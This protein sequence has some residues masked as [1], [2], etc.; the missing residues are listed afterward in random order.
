M[1]DRVQRAARLTAASLGAFLYA[2]TS[3]ATGNVAYW[4]E[5]RSTQLFGKQVI[6]ALADKARIVV[7]RAPAKGPTSGYDYPTVVARIKSATPG[8]PVLAYAQPLRIVDKGRIETDVLKPDLPVAVAA[9][10]RNDEAG[11][12]RFVDIDNDASRG[13]VVDTLSRARSRLNV[14]G[15]ALDLLTRT[16]S[17]VPQALAKRCAAEKDYCERYAAGVDAFLAELKQRLQAGY[18]IYNGLFTSRPGLLQ[19]QL[20]LLNTADAAIV[21]YFGLNPNRREHSFS[22]DI[23]PYLKAMQQL[24][25]D[26]ALF[27]FGRGP[28]SYT[29]Y[30]DDYRWQRYLYASFLLAARS[31]DSFKYH[32]SFQVPAHKGRSGGF[33]HYADWDL[34]LGEPLESMSVVNGLYQRR[35]AN[36]LVIVAPD[37][38]PGGRLHLAQPY[39]NPEGETLQG[40]L[41]FAAGEAAILLTRA[42][43]RPPVLTSFDAKAIA[44]WGWQ[45][46][47]LEQANGGTM[48]RLAPLPDKLAGEHD[49][50]LEHSRS[51][52]TFNTLAIDARLE[53][54]AAAIYAVAE[55]DDAR[56]EHMWLVVA[57]TRGEGIP[58]T[59]AERV[60]FRIPTPNASIPWPHVERPDIAS[61]MTLDGEAIA[62]KAGL[63]FRRWSHVRFSGQVGIFSIALTQPS[64]LR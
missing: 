35:F 59:S 13:L 12:I 26:K 62:A 30:V 7:I 28:W 60:L 3:A 29:D 49:L 17:P 48:L 22:I 45:H 52:S 47:A 61:P 11:T 20:R 64:A 42:P 21:E 15:F 58:A 6:A 24:P 33:D 16:P 56:R 31:Q 54:D 38:G 50:L 63:K 9:Q 40:D 36:G 19:D 14:D 18:L 5:P 8:T 57:I 32:A 51:L 37:D 53:S 27:V 39:A 41:R 25:P 43:E 34:N 1:S 23:L 4:L 10:T 55:V 2:A 44:A 46:A